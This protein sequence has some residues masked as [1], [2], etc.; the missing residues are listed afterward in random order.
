M[1]KF[2]SFAD[3]KAFVSGMNLKSNKERAEYCKS[4]NKPNN[5]PSNPNTVYKDNGWTT[6]G[7]YLAQ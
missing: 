7:D 4:G 3:A 5:I 1:N 6:W 2:L